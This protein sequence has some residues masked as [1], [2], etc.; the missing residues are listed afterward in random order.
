MLLIVY[1]EQGI[2]NDSHTIFYKRGIFAIK[3]ITQG[4]NLDIMKFIK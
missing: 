3:A 4:G 1:K 2:D